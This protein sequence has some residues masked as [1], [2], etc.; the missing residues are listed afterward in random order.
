MASGGERRDPANLRIEPIESIEPQFALK[1]VNC[2]RGVH[3]EV[4]ISTT[5]QCR[6]TAGGMVVLKCRNAE[7]G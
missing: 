7:V 1:N 3:G 4:Q 2:S 6:R 5:S